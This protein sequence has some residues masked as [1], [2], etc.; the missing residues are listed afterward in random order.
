MTSMSPFPLDD[1]T[2]VYTEDG[3]HSGKVSCSGESCSFFLDGIKKSTYFTIDY[4]VVSESDIY[5]LATD[6]QNKKYLLKNGSI[7]AS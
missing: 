7:I 6:Q 1:G 3:T 5:A 4:P 2:I